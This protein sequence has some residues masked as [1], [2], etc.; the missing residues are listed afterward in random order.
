MTKSRII[1]PDTIQLEQDYEL[2]G[3]LRQTLQLWS[4]HRGE[5]ITVKDATLQNF[6]A[7]VVELSVERA[8]I[9]IV[10]RGDMPVITDREFQREEREIILH[11]A[12]PEKERMEWIIQKATELGVRA[13]IPFKS[14]KST[15][16]EDR[17]RKQKKA[18]CWPR[19]ALRAAKQCRRPDI[20]Q[21]FPFCT[22]Q[23]SLH[24]ARQSGVRILL[25]EKQGAGPALADFLDRI[26]SG[27]KI[28]VM[29]GPEGG[30]T[31]DEVALARQEG[32]EPIH[33]GP[34]ILR[35]ETASLVIISIIQFVFGD[36]R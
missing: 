24:I 25:W 20:P 19:V 22:F 27:L 7:R 31:E 3:A 14:N 21:I 34:R 10:E 6:R 17:D 4:P 32:F 2:T 29:V 16:L 26:D 13:I 33:L 9:H 1:L 8:R 35:T 23:E 15:S 5:I 28:S 36:L 18:L 12:L 30:F 11:Q